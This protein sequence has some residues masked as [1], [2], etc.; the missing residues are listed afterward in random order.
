MKRNEVI[1]YA[2]GFVSF[3]L[4]REENIAG[5][6]LFG[7]VARGDFDRESDIDLFIETD[8][9]KKNIQNILDLYEKS[10]DSKKFRLS[11][12]ENSLALKVGKLEE[13]PSLRRSIQSDGIVLFGHFTE[14]PEGLKHCLQV[15]VMVRGKERK[16]KVRL[17]RMLYGYKQKVGK[18]IFTSQGI[19]EKCGGKK[20]SPG[21]FI[22]PIEKSKDIESFLNE[23]KIGLRVTDVYIK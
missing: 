12:I 4:K 1:S 16:E 17:W 18:K 15:K 22:I 5:V 23:N 11:G 6:I 10:E 14:L 2:A 8:E 19:I 7:S 13:W 3:L 9:P 21:V 20:V